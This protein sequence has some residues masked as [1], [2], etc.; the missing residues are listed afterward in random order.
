MEPWNFMTFHS[1]GTF[2][3]PTDDSSIIFQ[4]GRAQPLTSHSI[5]EI[6]SIIIHHYIQIIS[7]NNGIHSNM[8][9]K[10][11][12]NLIWFSHKCLTIDGHAQIISSWLYISHFVSIL[13]PL[14]IDK[15]W[16]PKRWEKKCQ[17][18]P[19]GGAIYGGDCMVVCND[20]HSAL[21]PMLIHAEKTTTGVFSTS[22][23]VVV[24]VIHSD[25]YLRLSILYNYMI[26]ICN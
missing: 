21:V 9:H 12:I 4:R 26:T 18:L 5:D 25:G 16:H 7:K 3:I 24:M 15:K 10:Y 6:Y 2:I 17:E 13:H 23:F 14:Y 22:S 11:P 20:W 19:L 1:I 8:Y